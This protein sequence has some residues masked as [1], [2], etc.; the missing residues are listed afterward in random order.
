VLGA[1]SLQTRSEGLDTGNL[2]LK[3][4]QFDPAGAAVS[5]EVIKEKHVFPITSYQ[6]HKL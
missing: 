5:T 6:V 3:T 1:T 4:W 2:E